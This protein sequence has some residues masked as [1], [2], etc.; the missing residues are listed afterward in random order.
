MAAASAT[1]STVNST[2]INCDPRRMRQGL[3][4]PVH[5]GSPQGQ[6]GG[7]DPDLTAELPR[8]HEREHDL[9]DVV[10]PTCALQ[11][12]H[13]VDRTAYV[14]PVGGPRGVDEPG[15]PGGDPAL[16]GG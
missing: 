9:R 2:A 11:W 6:A 13:R 16:R 8:P 4:C 1:A 5:R 3:A 14:V 7:H 10:R 15:G 12:R